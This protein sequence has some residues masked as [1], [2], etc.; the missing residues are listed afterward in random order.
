MLSKKPL[1]LTLVIAF[2]VHCS[3]VHAQGAYVSGVETILLPL[4]PVR[5]GLPELDSSAKAIAT[6]INDSDMPRIYFGDD[7]VLKPDNR[8]CF[9]TYCFSTYCFSPAPGVEVTVCS[10]AASD[11]DSDSEDSGSSDETSD[12]GSNEDKD[13]VNAESDVHYTTTTLN[14]FRVSDEIS[15][16]CAAPAL[17]N[18]KQEPVSDSETP[19]ESEV[20]ATEA[21]SSD[22]QKIILFACSTD[23]RPKMHQCD[24]QDCNYRSNHRGHLEAHK[25]THLPANQRSKVHQCDYEGCNY[26]TQHASHLKMHKQ[27]HLPTDQRP[28]MHQ[29]DHQGCNYSTRQLGHL[30]THKQTHLP[31]DQRPKMHQCDHQ[32]CNYSTRQSGH[33]KIHKQTH[34]P[35]DQRPKVHQC[36]HEGCNYITDRK[37]NL[38]AHKQT[39]LPADQ[40]LKRK[41]FDQLPSKKKR[42]KDDKK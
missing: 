27:T 6:E 2:S 19:T 17:K 14:P 26:G 13:E 41:A 42:K 38:K 31:A 33:L 28:K 7:I 25:Q 20:D 3:N 18:I 9:S 29:C 10:Q 34:L 12:N 5:D 35:V 24:H 15:E 37:G 23:Q 4:F 11:E 21:D 32:G 8:Y 40:R 1:I 39:H 16:Y 30:K 36:D 22:N